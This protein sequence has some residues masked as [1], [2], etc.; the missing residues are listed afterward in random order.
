MKAIEEQLQ[1]VDFSKYSKV[2]NALL[3]KMLAKR[4]AWNMSMEDLDMVVAAGNGHP[5]KEESEIIKK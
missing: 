5:K 4:K 3:L 1:N 2:Q